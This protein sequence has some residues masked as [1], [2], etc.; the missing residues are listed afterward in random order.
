[1]ARSATRFGSFD[2][3]SVDWESELGDIARYLRAVVL[4]L[5]PGTT[6][7]VRLGDNAA[8]FG[9]GPKK[10]RE[11]YCYIMPHKK[12]INLGFFH[13]VMVD[14]PAQLM[15][16]TGKKMRHVKIRSLDMAQQVEIRQLIQAAIVE[17]QTTLGVD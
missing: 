16:G 7:V 12:W 10:M 6:E 5:H 15:E 4:E 8:T 9:V 17:R 11:G 1:M 13:G 14:D 2:E 3:L